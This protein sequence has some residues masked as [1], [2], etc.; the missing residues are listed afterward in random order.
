M[1]KFQQYE[2]GTIEQGATHSP[3]SDRLAGRLCDADIAA[4]AMVSPGIVRANLALG[5]A[6]E[7]ISRLKRHEAL[8]YGAN[9]FWSTVSRRRPFCSNTSSPKSC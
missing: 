4:H 1:I 2:R 7:V 8:G 5:A 9:L 3:E 6:D